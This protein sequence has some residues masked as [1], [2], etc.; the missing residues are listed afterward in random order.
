MPTQVLQPNETDG[1]DSYGDNGSGGS[2]FGTDTMLK[3]GEEDSS[4]TLFRSFIKF[5]GLATLPAS[6]I[7][8][9][10]T[11]TLTVVND[12]SA[13][14]R[15]MRAYR[16]VRDWAEGTVTWDSPWA[17]AGCSNTTT[18]REA[19]DIGSVS[20]AASESVGTQK[21]I[22]LTASAVKQWVDGSIANYGLLLKMDT[23]VNDR[24][25]YASASHA[26][27]G[28]RP[29]LTTVYDIPSAPGVMIVGLFSDWGARHI[30][31]SKKMKKI[32]NP[33]D[34]PDWCPV[35]I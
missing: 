7:I 6:T 25:D 9:S 12:A 35:P 32:L 24:H 21:D 5:S 30:K 34:V 28:Y 14:A 11:L 31:W 16:I 1:I 20:V 4:S 15:T 10:S 2:N 18:D 8:Y 26:T 29:F 13:N 27:T 33:W 3:I 19:T 17:T 22:S 23:E